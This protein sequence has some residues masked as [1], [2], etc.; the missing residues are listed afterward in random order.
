MQAID[1]PHGGLVYLADNDGYLISHS[2]DT[3]TTISR[4]MALV[5][6]EPYIR[7]SAGV[8]MSV[9]GSFSNLL[10]AT[11]GV[12][13]PPFH[14]IVDGLAVSADRIDINAGLSL[15][16]ITVFPTD[17]FYHDLHSGDT[18]SLVFGILAFICSIF[19][20]Y[21]TYHSV[22]ARLSAGTKPKTPRHLNNKSSSVDNVNDPTA[23]AG[24]TG[25]A[26][27]AVGS[28]RSPKMGAV[29]PTTA[30]MTHTTRGM[31]TLSRAGRQTS[32]LR[33][34]ALSQQ[35]DQNTSSSSDD[36]DNDNDD[37]SSTQVSSPIAIRRSSR[38][39]DINDDDGNENGENKTDSKY[40]DN[41]SR[42]KKIRK[43]KQKKY[44][45]SILD[46]S[47]LLSP[48]TA[49]DGLLSDNNTSGGGGGGMK[50]VSSYNRIVGHTPLSHPHAH[51]T[52]SVWDDSMNDDTSGREDDSTKSANISPKL[53]PL[54]PRKR[55][56]KCCPALVHAC[57]H[58]NPRR[59]HR[60]EL[61]AVSF[62]LVE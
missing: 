61:K 31:R 49:S 34:K 25:T 7:F 11:E 12:T 29:T 1:L 47:P 2:G 10:I 57:R 17:Q 38:A 8:I 6:K 52:S 32:L 46:A 5:S 44:Q 4:Q 18:V 45:T 62:I 3:S 20:A 43:A 21:S 35:M 33:L 14:T 42:S 48:V 28:P 36:E 51:I 40:N 16:C 30:S 59:H 39:V 54:S 26:T 22:T 13:T 53:S 23:A 15:A 37:N 60:L 50:R 55:C 58:L 27:T 24:E 19:M 9:Y 41:G 56:S